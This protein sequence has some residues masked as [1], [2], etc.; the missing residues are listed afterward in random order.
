[1]RY[2][3]GVDEVS[4]VK[5]IVM[6]TLSGRTAPE[7]ARQASQL[8][9][10]FHSLRRRIPGLLRLEVGIDHSRVDHAC[11]VV[12]Y[13]EFAS[14]AAL[15]GY[16]THAEHLRVKE[17]VAGLRAGRWQVDYDEPGN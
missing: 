9:D 4:T 16:A 11:D 12:L 6:W 15:D 13:T 14:Q 2:W 3:K 17:E 1:M 8:R 7:R 5:H 10:S